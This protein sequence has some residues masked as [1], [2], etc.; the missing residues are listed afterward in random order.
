MNKQEEK[1]VDAKT[2][3]FLNTKFK[4]QVVRYENTQIVKTSVNV[5]KERNMTRRLPRLIQRENWANGKTN[6]RVE[7]SL[8]YLLRLIKN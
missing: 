4:M 7:M 8:Q 6:E 3:H 1:N 5:I 2:T